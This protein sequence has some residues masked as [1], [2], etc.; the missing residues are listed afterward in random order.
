MFNNIDL[1]NDMCVQFFST[2]L[3]VR[4]FYIKKNILDTILFLELLTF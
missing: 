3:I 2:N 4:N 1:V